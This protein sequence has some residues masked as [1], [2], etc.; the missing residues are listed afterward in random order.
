[1]VDLPKENKPKPEL[2]NWNL[3]KWNWRMTNHKQ[4]TKLSHI[5]QP[6]I[7]NQSNNFFALL[8]CL[9]H[10]NFAASFCHWNTPNH[11]PFGAAQLELLF[12]L[13]N[14]NVPHSTF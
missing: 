6:L 13:Q 9:L 1:M 7:Y 14:F 5:K 10:K 12:P 8:Q 4:Q 2:M 11:F 3:R